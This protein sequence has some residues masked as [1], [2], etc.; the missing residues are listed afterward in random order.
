MEKNDVLIIKKSRVYR[1]NF[2]SFTYRTPEIAD[3]CTF[4]GVRAKNSLTK[5]PG[6]EKGRAKLG[7]GTYHRFQFSI[8][9][10]GPS[11]S[12]F[13]RPS[14]TSPNIRDQQGRRPRKID[15]EA[16]LYSSKTLADRKGF[17]IPPG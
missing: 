4:F 11:F 16:K 5:L 9:T 15:R 7:N 1:N 8:R 10:K 17:H 12:F 3:R 13:E 2:P 14:S 6:V